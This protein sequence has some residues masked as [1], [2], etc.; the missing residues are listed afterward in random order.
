VL[1]RRD[2]CLCLLQLIRIHGDH[3]LTRAQPQGRLLCWHQLIRIHGGHV[4]T[5]AQPQGHLSMLASA[6]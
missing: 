1:S 2:I 3:V 4:L 5:R 6:D